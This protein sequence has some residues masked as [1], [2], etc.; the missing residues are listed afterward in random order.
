MT[1]SVRQ[2]KKEGKKNNRTLDLESRTKT[3]SFCLELQSCSLLPST[4]AG[5][6]PWGV[7]STYGL[8]I[9]CTYGIVMGCMC[10]RVRDLKYI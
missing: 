6:G 9:V 8:G 1:E 10:A 7:V 2:I 5:T 3:H 4:S